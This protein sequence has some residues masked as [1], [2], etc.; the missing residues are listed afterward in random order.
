VAEPS[1]NID[2]CM[3]QVDLGIATNSFLFA[4]GRRKVWIQDLN[5]LKDSMYLGEAADKRVKT[6]L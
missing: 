3:Q 6:V 2:L 1:V 4:E 5:S